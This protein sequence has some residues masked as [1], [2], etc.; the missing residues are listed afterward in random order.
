MSVSYVRPILEFNSV[1]WSP[2]LK[3]DIE[4]IEKVQRNFT[5]RLPGLK[6]V[7]YADRLDRL[8]LITLE[9]R[10]LHAD[11]IMCYKIVS[12]NVDLNFDDFFK[13]SPATV[14]RGHRYKLFVQRSDGIRTTFFSQ[15]V[16]N[17]WN[18]LPAITVNFDS[19]RTFKH[20]LK[21]IDFKSFLLQTLQ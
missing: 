7:S 21:C 10:R 4:C 19:V 6:N 14:T 18:F 3:C 17:V 16:I 2:T 11:L 13:Y 12:G 1:V 5:K 9:L 20:S 15:R 8:N